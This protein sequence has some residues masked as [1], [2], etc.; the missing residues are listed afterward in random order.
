MNCLSD[1]QDYMGDRIEHLNSDVDRLR[2]EHDAEAEVSPRLDPN[3]NSNPRPDPITSELVLQ[4]REHVR[5]GGDQHRTIAI[6]QHRL[7]ARKEHSATI[8][9]GP[10]ETKWGRNHI[11]A[12][13]NALAKNFV[14]IYR[15]GNATLSSDLLLPIIIE[16]RMNGEP[17]SFDGPPGFPKTVKKFLLMDETSIQNLIDYYNIQLFLPIEDATC[18]SS[19]QTEI[20]P[21]TDNIKNYRILF[22]ME[23]ASVLHI[24]ITR[25]RCDPLKPEAVVLRELFRHY[26]R[27]EKENS[28]TYESFLKQLREKPI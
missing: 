14:G 16:F 15:N 20:I 12:C 7:L 5:L 13:T 11:T 21:N 6:S 23:L 2:I 25:L 4:T 9:W 3:A 22:L 18:D 8:E 24:R 26:R 10:R 19:E 17:G 1:R 28:F 27:L